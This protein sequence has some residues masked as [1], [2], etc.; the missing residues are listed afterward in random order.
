MLGRGDYLIQSEALADQD[1]WH[2]AV[3]E[4]DWARV[5]Q[6]ADHALGLTLDTLRGEAFIDRTRTAPLPSC[7]RPSLQRKAA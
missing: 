3:P 2:G 5:E 4:A 7:K 1:S 6:N